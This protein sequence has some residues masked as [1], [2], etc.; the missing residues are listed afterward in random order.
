MSLGS[1]GLIGCIHCKK[2]WR[3]FVAQTFALIAPI[4]PILHRVSCSNEMAPNAPKHCE[5]QQNMSFGSNGVDQVRSLQKNSDPTSWHEL[6]QYL[7]HFSPFCTESHAVMKRSQ[8]HST[9]KKCTKNEYRIQSGVS[10]AF[11]AKKS[12]VTSWQELLH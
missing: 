11:V 4:L 8:M 2:F 12:V 7:H 1:N 9:T 6:L 10:G 5:I 3:N